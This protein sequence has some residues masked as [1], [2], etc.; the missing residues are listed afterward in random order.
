MIDKII[1]TI[2]VLVAIAQIV[3][4]GFI[5]VVT[6]R[7]SD[8]LRPKGRFRNFLGLI[9]TAAA[10][11]FGGSFIS[12]TLP[13]DTISKSFLEGIP[14]AP[15]LNFFAAVNRILIKIND[16]F[17]LLRINGSFLLTVLA[18]I[19][20]FAIWVLVMLRFSANRDEIAKSDEDYARAVDERNKNKEKVGHFEF[21]TRYDSFTKRER[22]TGR[23]VDDTKYEYAMS[24]SAAFILGILF[25]FIFLPTVTFVVA[26]I[27][28]IIGIIKG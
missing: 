5:I 3:A 11:F 2:M 14:E 27:P 26:L 28:F 25:S 1:A 9:A 4:C 8:D 19:G 10:L 15:G 17:P 13:G 6:F 12:A 18:A 16:L 21:T 20:I 24:S 7:I 22:T 23:Y